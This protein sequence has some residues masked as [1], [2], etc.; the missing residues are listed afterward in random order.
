[1]SRTIALKY[2]LP[3]LVVSAALIMSY[4]LIA[5][6]QTNSSPNGP[7]DAEITAKGITF[8]IPELGNCSSKDSCRDY[9]S[10]GGNMD[11]CIKFAQDRGLMNKVEA[12]QA[13][14][15][16]ERLAAGVGPGGCNS[17][18]SCKSFCSNTANLDTCIQFAE[19]NGFKE[20]KIEEAKKVQ[21]FLKSGGQMPG[22]C[23]SEES[24][25]AYC[26]DFSHAKEC[27]EFAQKSGIEQD[28]NERGGKLESEQFKKFVELAEK[29][30]TPGGCKSK[31]E[32]ESYCQKESNKEGCIAFGQ[33][34]GFIDEG[35]AEAFRKT[36]GKGPGGCNS[37]ESCR[38]YCNDPGNQEACFKFA[39]E[40]SLINQ[41]E[42]KNAKEGFVRLRQG[43]EQAPPE[44]ANCLKS[45]LGSNIIEDIQSGNL[46]PGPQI[47]DRV[48][49]CFEKFGHSSDAREG[50]NQAPSEVSSC[51]REKLGNVF[52]KV[53]SG[54]TAP[55]PEM[56][57]AF[58]VCGEQLRL[59]NQSSTESGR[60]EAK[61]G[62]TD[63]G[64]FLRSA[65]PGVAGCLK[66]QLGGDFERIKSGE[67][68]PGK[69]IKERLR[70]CFREFRPETP[71]PRGDKASDYEEGVMPT[72]I[73]EFRNFI[74][75]EGTSTPGGFRSEGMKQGV[76]GLRPGLNQETFEKF[77]QEGGF[78]PPQGAPEGFKQQFNQPFQDQLRQQFQGE[79]Q[80]HLEGNQ[81]IPPTSP[82]QPTSPPSWNPSSPPSE[83]RSPTSPPPSNA[84]PAPIPVPAPTLT[85]APKP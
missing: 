56:A 4:A 8:P 31:E 77:R 2:S 59:L 69:E 47:G 30:E 84:A 26:G 21:A 79:F 22:G 55:T 64:N 11:A 16:K 61:Q 46:T 52:E 9:C 1:M 7:S 81:F 39:G 17:P 6:A 32:C 58:R 53:H 28:Q 80:K 48:K 44:V 82:T 62:K 33:K 74:R 43:L 35:K 71:K 15:F 72:G 27:F 63:V 50:F 54:E 49:G 40:H 25:R 85:P 24:C 68:Q 12:S 57:D 3:F 73:K 45:T 20:G 18:E 29:G 66:E 37:E 19:K 76:D 65:P 42:I 51:V 14:K 34:M 5:R 83:F 10:K 36:G 60:P 75:H 70:A 41:E 38:A 67:T 13:T 23:N 78:H